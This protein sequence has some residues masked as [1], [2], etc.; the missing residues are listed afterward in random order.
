M[1]N[2]LIQYP[3]ENALKH[4]KQYMKYPQAEYLIKSGRY[5]FATSRMILQK[6]K[7]IKFF[8]KWLVSQ[9]NHNIDTSLILQINASIMQAICVCDGLIKRLTNVQLGLLTIKGRDYFRNKSLSKI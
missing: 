4:L 7:K 2:V 5:R 9:T 3:Y 8:H 6:K 1:I